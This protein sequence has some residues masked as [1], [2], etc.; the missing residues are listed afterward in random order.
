MGAAEALY[1]TVGA[2][3]PVFDPNAY[4]PTLAAV[5][6][7]VDEARVAEAWEEGRALSFEQAIAEA[8]AA[9]DEFVANAPSIPSSHDWFR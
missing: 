1:E 5:H 2:K 6:A 4:E 7:V 8:L 3:L 9:A